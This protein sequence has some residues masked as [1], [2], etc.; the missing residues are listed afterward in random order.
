MQKFYSDGDGKISRDE[1]F[2]A[3]VEASAVLEYKPWVP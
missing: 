3:H 1:F 2:D